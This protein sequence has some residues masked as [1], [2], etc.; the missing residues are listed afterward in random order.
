MIIFLDVYELDA[1]MNEQWSHELR[2]R[3]S[4]MNEKLEHEK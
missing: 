1:C 4:T 2:W 3:L